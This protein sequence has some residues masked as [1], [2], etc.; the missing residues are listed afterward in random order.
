VA[1]T[2]T[3]YST[4]PKTLTEFFGVPAGLIKAVEAAHFTI[5]IKPNMV[6]LQGPF[7]VEDA[8]ADGIAAFAEGA[9]TL[10]QDGELSEATRQAIGFK[11]AMM[12]NEHVGKATGVITATIQGAAS[13]H[14][15]LG[16]AAEKAKKHLDGLISD[17]HKKA[18]LAIFNA[19]TGKISGKVAAIAYLRK[20]TGWGLIEAKKTV[21][22]WVKESLDPNYVAPPKTYT[23]T[24]EYGAEL[25]APEKWKAECL[26][27][28]QTN[29]DYFDKIKAIKWLRNKSGWGLKT[30]KNQV[31]AWLQDFKDAGDTVIFDPAN[32]NQPIPGLSKVTGDDYANIANPVSSTSDP[33]VA[34]SHAL[35]EIMTSD[36]VALRSAI[37]LYQ[38]V[39]SSSAG[40][41]YHCVALGPELRIAAR[42]KGSKLSIRVEGAMDKPKILEAYKLQLIAMGYKAEYF[43]KGYTSIHV[44][45]EDIQTAQM[46]LGALIMG[47]DCTFDT[48][49]PVLSFFKGYGV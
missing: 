21:E 33:L 7:G 3:E 6:L 46:A 4:D 11:I 37:D 10:A 9:L 2:I 43:V 22:S 31:E 29:S 47:I 16:N 20:V 38:P 40:S 13:A 42:Y 25:E 19:S 49:M 1:I 26:K 17:P 30:A 35:K 28:G 36:P 44:E 14:M 39:H 27:A 48:Q 32:P 8:D 5:V 24:D 34:I 15:N 41:I 45:A 23:A 18:T 12:L